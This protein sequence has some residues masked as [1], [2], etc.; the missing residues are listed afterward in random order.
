MALLFWDSFDHYAAAG[1]AQKHLS[2]A[3]G[4]GGAI[5]VGAWGRFTTNGLRITQ[6]S[7]GDV[8]IRGPVSS[9]PAEI[10]LGIALWVETMPD[11]W[12]DLLRFLDNNERQVVIKLLSTGAIQALRD[13]TVLGASAAGE[14]AIDTYYYLEV[15][16][17]VDNAAGSVEVRLTDP[18]AGE[19]TILN[20]AGVDTQQSANAQVTQFQICGD[21]ASDAQARYMRFDDLY[22][23][24]NAGA[25]CNDFLGD[26]RICAQFATADG[27]HS[28]FMPLGGGDN[29]EEI[30][31]NPPD[32]DTSYNFSS[33]PT[34]RDSFVMEDLPIGAAGVIHAV[35]AV[36]DH[37]KD[38]AG[39]RTIEP[40]V[41]I[42]GVDYDGDGKNTP[43]DYAFHTMYAWEVSPATLAAWS[44]AE[45]NG[46]ELGY[47]L[48]A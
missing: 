32:D 18:V 27:A 48:T 25:Q 47:E 28:D 16:V 33:T 2:T 36:M 12:V 46:A 7:G 1:L 4:V 35:C 22:V 26:T 3:V 10:I 5:D 19:S 20:L 38:D 9:R 43:N 41:R 15:K 37:R 31:D 23:C 14:V 45:V 17:V 30:D 29:Y 44:S 34:D 11:N 40:S 6:F 13:T 39:T 8:Y 24:D 42:G 21:G